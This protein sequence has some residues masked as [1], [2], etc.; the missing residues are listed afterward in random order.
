VIIDFLTD[1]RHALRALARRPGFALVCVATIALG[2]GASTAM[3]A[4]VYRL[5]IAP[6]PFA[7]GDRFGYPWLSE[8]QGGMSVTPRAAVVA[9]WQESA[10]T[11]ERI[12]VYS[13]AQ[14][15]LSG[16]N[17]PEEVPGGRLSSTL[18]ATLGVRPVLGRFFVAEDA[19]PGAEAVALLSEGMW[20]Q[21]FGGDAQ[22]IGRTITLDGEPHAVVGV[23]P[24]RLAAFDGF[25]EPRDVWVPVI[26]DTAAAHVNVLIK[27]RKGVTAEA[28]EAELNAIAERVPDPRPL[29]GSWKTR[30]RT[31]DYFLG[32]STRRGL[33]ILF[34]AVGVVLLIACA[35]VAGLLLA[36]GESRRRE[37]AI[38]AAIGAGRGRILR[39]LAAES[40]LLAIVGGALGLLVATWSLD[41]VRAV[42]PRDLTALDAVVLEPV[43]VGFAIALSLLTA[44][45]FGFGPALSA[46]RTV[47]IET[48]KGATGG[49]TGAVSSARLRALL[50]TSQIALSLVLLV[51][52]AL[53]IR[54]LA[55]L[56]R[57]EVGFQMDGLLT[58]G[59]NLPE[60]RY[61][62]PEARALFFQQAVEGLQS[63]QRVA[64][65]TVT[66]GVPP[67]FGA[68]FG[69]LAI[70][71]KQLTGAPRRALNSARVDASFFRTMGIPLL[72]GRSFA[73]NEQDEVLVINHA[74]ARTYWPGESA[75][76]KRLRVSAEGPW[77]TVIG[78]VADVAASGLTSRRDSEQLYFPPRYSWGDLQLVVRAA[79]GDPLT[80]LPGVRALVA[81]IDPQLPIRE[82]RTVRSLMAQSVARERFNTSI[83]TVFAAA[84]L[85]LAVIGLYGLISYSVAQRTRE[86]GV[87]IA[88]G[89]APRSVQRLV[90][91]Q[92][93]GLT[94]LGLAIGGLAAFWLVRL[95]EGLLHGF[96]PRDP[97]AFGVAALAIATSALLASYVPAVRA[98]AVDPLSALRAE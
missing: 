92:A 93:L 42:R 43:V 17:L 68:L 24:A 47:L 31:P 29:P 67:R 54:S 76:G 89:A 55:H 86:I 35:N 2:I 15:I 73:E 84:A 95:L 74:M 83:L 21:R 7:D 18:A 62:S 52:A 23:M 45:V 16:E 60:G 44:V 79:S 4:V 30:I 94:A 36:R 32:T 85:L 58:F 53:L 38:R 82:P 80:L 20:K 57:R 75:V 41:L 88:L 72:E 97:L 37:I 81:R 46:S 63:L 14:F 77:H 51:G 11:P 1:L 96:E 50:V 98:S 40:L 91:R 26:P 22:V 34:P 90:V 6:L 78:V 69:S 27:L 49:S 87:R 33:L 39:F 3:S 28:A 5:L 13:P 70:E 25:G 8:E 64:S 48:M 9:A 56:Q 19:R 59:V 10:R 12:E 66:S 65:V 71:G 61:G